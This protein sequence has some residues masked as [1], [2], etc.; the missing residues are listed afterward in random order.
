MGGTDCRE[1]TIR[2][3]L[4]KGLSPV[5]VPGGADESLLSVTHH[6]HIRMKHKGFIRVAIQTGTAIV[7]MLVSFSR[8]YQVLLWREQLVVHS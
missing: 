1:V 8:D 4:S 6:N 7:P 5:V 3:L 2:S